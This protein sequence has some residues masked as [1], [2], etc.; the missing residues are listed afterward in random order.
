[1]AQGLARGAH[2]GNPHVSGEL[3]C[4]RLLCFA[5]SHDV[6]VRVCVCLVPQPETDVPPFHTSLQCRYAL[7]ARPR[8]WRASPFKTRRL[9]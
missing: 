4:W 7:R 8:R 2:P 9:M 1:M 5:S 3:N 6:C